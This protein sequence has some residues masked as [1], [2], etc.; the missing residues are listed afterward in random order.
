MWVWISAKNI[1]TLQLLTADKLKLNGFTEKNKALTWKFKNKCQLFLFTLLFILVQL[2]IDRRSG[3]IPFRIWQIWYICMNWMN[4]R[5]LMIC[6]LICLTQTWPSFIAFTTIP[7]KTSND[8]CYTVTKL[9]YKCSL[10]TA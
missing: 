3:Y 6:Y 10:S 8:G 1:Y 2:L 5:W 7:L 9:I 4:K